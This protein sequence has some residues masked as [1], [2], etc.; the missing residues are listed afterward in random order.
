MITRAESRVVFGDFQGLGHPQILEVRQGDG[1]PQLVCK[2]NHLSMGGGEG[3]GDLDSIEAA[4]DRGR[5][6]VCIPGDEIITV[7]DINGDRCQDLV[8]PESRQVLLSRCDG[9]FEAELVE[10][11]EGAGHLGGD[12]GWVPKAQDY[13]SSRSN[14][15]NTLRASRPDYVDLDSDNDGIYD[16]VM[17]MLPFL[18]GLQPIR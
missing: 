9:R 8:F 10:L 18:D 6:T 5:Q 16:E 14:K 12:D 3:Q 17:V 15:P 2:S 13:H 4:L 1:E 11:P 7:V